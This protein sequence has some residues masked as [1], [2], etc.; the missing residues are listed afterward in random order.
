MSEKKKLV[1][2]KRQ[3][4]APRALSCVFTCFRG[5]I[6]PVQEWGRRKGGYLGAAECR[7]A[8]TEVGNREVKR[9]EGRKI[10]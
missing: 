4:C 10:T 7:Q 1:G 5:P 3:T 6:S 2:R 8:G 9:E